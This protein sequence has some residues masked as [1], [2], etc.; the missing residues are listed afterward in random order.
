MQIYINKLSL[1]YSLL[2][3][4]I[5]M[6]KPRSQQI[7]LLDTQYYHICSRTVRK[8]FLCGVDKTQVQVMS[9]DEV[10]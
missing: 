10:G 8:A 5:V 3:L 6:P 4:V 2:R 9:T 1:I 7:S